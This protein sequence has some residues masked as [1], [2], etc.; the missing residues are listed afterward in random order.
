MELG[1]GREQDY[2]DIAPARRDE[3]LHAQLTARS[4]G[5]SMDRRLR[6]INRFAAG[7]TGYFYLADGTRPFSELDE[8]LRRRLRQVRWKEWRRPKTRRRNL[9][10]LGVPEQKAR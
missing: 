10:A 8:W 4:W 6:A 1:Q 5:V 9:L 7:W 3:A 2:G